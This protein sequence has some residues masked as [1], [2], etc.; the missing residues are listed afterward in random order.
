MIGI[1]T[2]VL[3]RY[4][5]QDDPIQSPKATRLIESLTPGLQGYITLVSVIELV[6]VLSGCYGCGRVE[7]AEI[8][9]RLLRA[10]EFV[11]AEIDVLQETIPYYETSHGDFADC[12]IER[13]T[14]KA[15]CRQTFTFDRGAAKH[16]GMTLIQ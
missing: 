7:I 16:C 14:H 11:I 6:W 5:T 4:L 8:L 9:K 12:L 1:D 2:N 15:G 10:E 3:V 13:L